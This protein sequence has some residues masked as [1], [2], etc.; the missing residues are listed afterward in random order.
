MNNGGRMI[1]LAGVD[2][3][4]IANNLEPLEPTNPGSFI[5]DEIECRGISQKQ[6]ASDMGV[7][8]V[9]LNDMLNEKRA[10]SPQYALL[11]EAALG[12]PA[13]ILA[14]MQSDYDMIHA[15]QNKTFMEKLKRVRRV[16]AVL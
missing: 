12:I 15:K 16:A 11:F 2:P 8:Y 1:T 3:N 4:M 14:G 13:Y 9:V 5:K 10:V 6:L 7:S